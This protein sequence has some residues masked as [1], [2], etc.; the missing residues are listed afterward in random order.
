MLIEC[1]FYLGV[2]VLFTISTQ[3]HSDVPPELIEF[4]KYRYDW[5]FQ[6]GPCQSSVCKTACRHTVLIRTNIR[7]ILYIKRRPI[8]VHWD[9]VP[10]K[11]SCKFATAD[12]Q[13]NKPYDM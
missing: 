8:T 1:G 7:K 11:H 3:F 10:E 9:A 4:V 12:A 13:R 5:Y 2:D 6:N